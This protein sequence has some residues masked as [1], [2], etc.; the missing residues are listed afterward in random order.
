M[1]KVIIADDSATMRRLLSRMLRN[2][3]EDLECLM[4]DGGDGVLKFLDEHTDIDLVLLDWN[5]HVMSGL[6]CLSAIRSREDTKALPVVMVTAEPRMNEA[7]ESGANSY[8][9][10]PFVPET[11]H[12]TISPFLNS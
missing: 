2:I 12:E 1:K 11:F 9:M 4:T 6:E 5:M 8:L 3:E 10:K 7:I